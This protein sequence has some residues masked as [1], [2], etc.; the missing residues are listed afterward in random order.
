M[1]TTIDEEDSKLD[2]DDRQVNVNVRI[3]LSGSTLVGNRRLAAN[4]DDPC[5]AD[6]GTDGGN[7]DDSRLIDSSFTCHKDTP[8]SARLI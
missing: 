4:D 3:A 2:I 7:S 5:D 6:R 1:T 8:S